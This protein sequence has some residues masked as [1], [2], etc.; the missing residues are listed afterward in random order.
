MKNGV[1]YCGVFTLNCRI[2]SRKMINNF[3]RLHLFHFI[4]SSL[5]HM[6]ERGREILTKGIYTRQVSAPQSLSDFR[7]HFEYHICQA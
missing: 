6:E 7:C 3:S 1:V 5:K 4:T 2:C